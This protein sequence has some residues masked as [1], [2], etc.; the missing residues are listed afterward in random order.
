V[1]DGPLVEHVAALERRDGG[2]IGV[3][4]S[5][6]LA[7]SLLRAGLVDELR[8]VVAPTVAGRGRR[9]FGQDEQ[10]R[11]ELVDVARTPSGLVLLHHRR[12]DPS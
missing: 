2:D 4:G 1:V 12:A 7:R 6:T 3:H 11:F 5:A 8:L 9:L 10:Q